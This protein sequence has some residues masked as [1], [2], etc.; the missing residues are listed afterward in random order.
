MSDTSVSSAAPAAAPATSSTGT[1]G[2]VDQK[3]TAA[4]D[5]KAVAAETSSSSAIPTM[6]IDGKEVAI[7]EELIRD[8][9][10]NGAADKRMKEAAE[11]K[12]SAESE[13]ARIDGI[14][15]SLKKGDHKALLAAGLTPDESRILAYQMVLEERKQYEEDERLKQMDPRD[16]ELHDLKAKLKAIDDAKAK[17]EDDKVKAEAAE[18]EEKV[19]RTLQSFKTDITRTIAELPEKY[20]SNPVVMEIV[21]S[22]WQWMYQNA[23]KLKS[24]GKLRAEDLDHKSIAKDVMDHFRSMGEEKPAAK[25]ADAQP[26]HPA[27]TATPKVRGPAQSAPKKTRLTTTE[28]LRYGPNGKP[29]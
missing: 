19:Q 8:L 14:F 15:Q 25:A 1:A 26:A 24:E 9:Q 28:L 29:R 13:R 6:K 17:T 10:K 18:R 4:V 11:M 5:P 20:R 7:T 2:P 16:R 21:Q 12:K 22:G 3:V 27:L 23:D